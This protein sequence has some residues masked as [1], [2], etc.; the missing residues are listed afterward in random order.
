MTNKSKMFYSMP[1]VSLNVIFMIQVRTWMML[2][3]V[4]LCFDMV[5][6]VQAN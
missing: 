6:D 4:I 3:F 2:V 5:K 1:H